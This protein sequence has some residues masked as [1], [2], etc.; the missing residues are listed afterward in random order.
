MTK[1]MQFKA[2]TIELGFWEDAD[3]F[4]ITDEQWRDWLKTAVTSWKHVR[5]PHF[6]VKTTAHVQEVFTE[7]EM[8]L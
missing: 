5:G 7:E 2:V 1:P 6:S 4:G 3:G 8:G